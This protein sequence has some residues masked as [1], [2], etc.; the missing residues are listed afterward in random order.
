MKI[1]IIDEFDESVHEFDIANEL[2]DRAYNHD[3]KDALY[4]IALSISLLQEMSDLPIIDMMSEAWNEG[5]GSKLAGEWLDDYYDN[6]ED[7]RYDAWA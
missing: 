6:E 2:Y 1:K 4:D 3:D 5:E 7:G